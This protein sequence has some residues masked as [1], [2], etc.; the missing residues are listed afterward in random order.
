MS[1]SALASHQQGY[2]AKTF[3]VMAMTTGRVD[4]G[5]VASL[6]V[7]LHFFLYLRRVFLYYFS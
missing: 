4:E 1:K 2:A 7:G 3:P 6:E 5:A